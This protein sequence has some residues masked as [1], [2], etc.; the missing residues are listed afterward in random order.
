MGRFFDIVDSPLHRHSFPIPLSMEIK[1]VL[2]NLIGSNSTLFTDVAGTKGKLVELS[3]LLTFPGASAQSIHSDIPYGSLPDSPIGAPGLASVFV[4]LQEINMAMGPTFIVPY[5]HLP[6]YHQTV[7]TKKESYNSEGEV[8]H[9]VTSGTCTGAEHPKSNDK[10]QVI[11]TE[12][13]VE[14]GAILCHGGESYIMDS[15][16]AHLGGANT[17]TTPRAVLCFAFQR[18]NDVKV[19]GFTYHIDEEVDAMKYTV[20]DFC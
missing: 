10:G 14:K 1:N 16:C 20:Q 6:S 2:N 5:T 19:K 3:V 4:A 7:V 18:E 9:V 11:F 8:E 12:Q 15:R 17:S 13:D